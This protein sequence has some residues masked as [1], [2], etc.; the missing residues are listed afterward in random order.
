MTTMKRAGAVL[1]TVENVAMAAALCGMVG[2][3]LLQI[4]SRLVLGDALSW[5]TEV[6]T[7]LLLWSALLGFAVGVRE[8]GHVALTILEDRL[9]GLPLYA[10]RVAQLVVFAFLLGALTYG[11]IVMVA[12]ELGAVSSAGIPRWIPFASVPVGCAL[13]LV[14]VVQHAFR[15]GGSGSGTETEDATY[16]PLQSEGTR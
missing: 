4:V 6:A 11:G 1:A 3:V 9:S 8:R 12:G 14:H 13:G 5:S 2:V 7:D 16:R 10:I 15:L